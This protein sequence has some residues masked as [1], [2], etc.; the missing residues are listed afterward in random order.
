[1]SRVSERS[2][3]DAAIEELNERIEKLEAMAHPPVD[4]TALVLQ[5]AETLARMWE[6]DPHQFSMRPCE[7]CRAASGL[8]GRPFGCAKRALEKR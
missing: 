2:L 5:H 7:T 4:V 8:L 3:A 6:S 1:M